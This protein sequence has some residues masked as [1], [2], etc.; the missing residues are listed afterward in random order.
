MKNFYAV[1][2][3]TLPFFLIIIS[4]SLSWAQVP[5]NYYDGISG[6]GYTLKTNLHNLI[7]GHTSRTYDQLW[8]DM[9]STD[10]D[11]VYEGDGTV[12]DMYSEN[13]TGADPYNFTW[14]TDQCGNYG[15]EG[16]CYNREHSFPKSW[17]ND[18][19]P[20]YTDLFHLYPTDGYV[21]GQRGNFPFG[22]TDSPT[23]TS[24]NGSEKGPSS[25]P[26]YTGTVFEP[27]EEF[28]GDFARTYFYMATRYEDVI[29]SWPGSDMLDGSSD[30]VFT[31]WALNML[32]DWHET[33]AVSQKEIDRN[34]AVYD[35]QGNANPFIDH[36]EWVCEIWGSSCGP[37][38]SASASNISG[39]TYVVGNGP[40]A[41]Q[42]FELSG[43]NLDGS[44]VTLTAPT[45]Y[46]ISTDNSTFSGSLNVNYTA[47]TLSATTIYIRLKSGLAEGTY[48]N[49]VVTCNDNGTASNVTVSNSGEVTGTDPTLS[50]NPSSL[51]GFS[52]IVGNGPSTAQSFTLSGTYLDGTQVSVTAP[53]NYEIS[54]DNTTFQNNLS[55]GYTA[56]DLNTTTIY[57][58]L[59]AGLSVGT[60]NSEDVICSDNGTAPNATVTNSGTVNSSS[61]C[62]NFDTGLASSYTTG[63]QT[64]SSGDWYTTDVFAEASSDARGGTG[65]AARINDD[66][67]GASLRTPALSTVGNITFWYR[68]LNSGGGTFNIEKS[69]DGSTWTNVTSQAFSGATYTEFS[70]DINDGSNPVYI[71]I[72]N[73]N[74][75]GHLIIDD[76][77]WIAY[78]G[79]TPALSAT[80][81]SLSGYSY[82]EGS[83]PSTSQSFSLSGSDL[84]GT[85]IT[86]SA[87]TNYEVSLDDS[88]FGTSQS[89]TTAHANYDGTVLSAV[90][91][92]IRL[93]AGLAVATYNSENITVSGG[94]ASNISVANNGEVT[95]APNPEPDNYP[96]SFTATTNGS[97][98]IDLSWTDATGTNL[99]DG[100]LI[101]ANTTGTF[102]DPADTTDPTEDSD[103]SDG[104]AT[105]KV[106]HGSGASYSF[107]GLNAST[108]YYF[109]IWPYSNSGSDIDFKTDGTPPEANATTDASVGPEIIAVQDFDGSTPD[110]PYTGTGNEGASFGKT[111]N[112][113]QIGGSNNLNLNAVDVSAY[114]SM[115]LYISDASTGGVEN[116]DALEIYVNLNGAGFPAMPDVKIQESD[117]NDNTYNA[118]WDYAAS[119]TA[120]TTAG[121]PI[122]VQGDGANGFSNIEITI[123]DGTTSVEL[124][125][126]A[127]NNNTDEY[128][129]LDDIKIEGVSGNS[130]DSDTEVTAGSGSEPATIAST[131]DAAG[132][133]IMVFDFTFTDAG[134]SD[135]LATIIDEIQITQGSA[136]DIP[137][138]TNAIAG[139]YLSG[140]DLASDLAGTVNSTN[141]T[142]AGNDM[143]S[144]A[145]NS[146]ETYT[147]KIYLRTNLSGITDNDNL[148]FALNYTNITTDAA[149]SS[150]GLGAPES[151]DANAAVTITATQLLFVSQ[152]STT[153]VN[154]VMS[155]DPTV[156]AC[157]I[158]GNIDIDYSQNISVTSSGSLSGT[159]V[160][161]TWSNGTATFSNLTHTATGTGLTLTASDGNL[162]DELSSTFDIT[163]APSTGCASDLLISEYYEG[164]SN[165]KYI[166]IY[167]GTSSDTDL[168]A[169][170]ISIYANGSSTASSEIPL[171]GTIAAGSA[172]IIANSS[173]NGTILAL[174][175]A[176]SGSLGFNG[177]DAVALRTSGGVLV[178]VIGQIGSD[179]GTEW[180]SGATSTADNTLI[181]KAEV[182]QGDTDGSNVFDPAT[183]WDGYANT[184]IYAGDHTMICGPQITVNPTSLAFGDQC[185]N[186]TSA[187]MTYTVSGSDLTSDISITAPTGYEISETSGSGFS[188]SI[189]L[190]QSGG[191]VASTTVY[192]RFTPTSVSAYS[193]NITHESTG[194]DIKYVALSGNGAENP[195]TIDSPSSANI[196]V[197]SADLGGTVT[198]TGCADVTERGIYYNTTGGFSPPGE[199]IKV[200]ETPG[201]YNTGVFS[202]NVSGLN[203]LTT[204]Y[205]QAFAT[206]S[207]GT[208]YTS[209]T[210]FT[211]TADQTSEVYA[212]GIQIPGASIASTQTAFTDAFTFVIKDNGL[213]SGDGLNT[214]VTNV[215]IY[216]HTG[217]TA[218]WTN[219]IQAVKLNDGT[220]ITLGTIDITD[221][222]INI[223]IPEGNLSANDDGTEKTVTLSFQLN[224][225]GLVDN[226]V[227]SFMI[228][229]DNHNFSTGSNS[230]EFNST[231]TG[232]DFN[233]GNFTISVTATELQFAANEPPNVG[234]I[235]QNMPTSVNAV[236]ANGNIDINATDEVTLSKAS[237]TGNMSP[238]NDIQNLVNGTYSW[239]IQFDASDDYTVTAS[240]SGLTDVT[241]G[242]ISITNVFAYQGFNSLAKDNWSYSGAVSEVNHTA[243]PDDLIG[244]F[245]DTHSGKMTGG[246][247]TMDNIDLLNYSNVT[248]SFRFAAW[249][250]GSGDELNME[251]SYDG[252]AGWDYVFV[253]AGSREYIA[254]GYSN[255][256]YD[257]GYTRDESTEGSGVDAPYNPWTIS[258]P[259][260]ET[261]FMVRFGAGSSGHNYYLEDVQLEGTFNPLTVH[262]LN[263][264]GV[265]ENSAIVNS[266]II[267]DGDLTITERGII[268]TED[269]APA[270][271][272][273]GEAGVTKIAEGNT[274]LGYYTVNIGGLTIG[275]TYH[276]RAYVLTNSETQYGETVTFTTCDGISECVNN[277]DIIISEY[278]ES[279]GGGTNNAIELYNGTG[280]DVNLKHYTLRYDNG[281]SGWNIYEPS[282]HHELG[283]VV[284]ANGNTYVIAHS[285]ANAPELELI[286]SGYAN[287]RINLAIG[288]DEQIQLLK[289]GTPIE[290]VGWE[291][292]FGEATTFA[293][294]P[295]IISP[296]TRTDLSNSSDQSCD[297]NTN[298]EWVIY[299]DNYY[300]DLSNHRDPFTWTGTTSS[301]WF[302]SS[303]WNLSRIP[304][305]SAS[306]VIDNTASNMP[307]IADPLSEGNEA[308]AYNITIQSGA[309]LTIAPS[310]KMTIQNSVTLNSP[311]EFIIQS[312][313]AGA[314]SLIF[315]GTGFEATVE[316]YLIGSQWHY[317]FAPLS[318][319]IPST[320]GTHNIYSY[321]ETQKDYWDATTNYG[322]SGWT[323]ETESLMLPNS[324]GFIHNRYGQ[325]SATVS[326]TGGMLK[327]ADKTFTVSH[328]ESGT[329]SVNENGVTEDWTYFD[330]WNLVGNPF[331]S[332]IDWD[333]VTKTNIESGIYVFDGSNYQYYISGGTDSPYNIG[334][335][336]NGGSRY[337]PA[338][339]GFMVKAN[340]G[341]GSF[342]IP[343]AAR[344][345]NSQ[346]FWK[347]SE[348]S[349]PNLLRI[350][351][352]K[353][354]F[355]DE[356]VF[357]TLPEETGVS[358]EHDGN[359]DAYKMFSLDK[360]KAQIFTQSADGANLY[361]VNSMTEISNYR[362]V[363]IGL[364]I[365]EAGEY[366][367][368]IKDN[369]F[370][371]MHLWLE[372]THNDEMINLRTVNNWTL[373]QTAEDN[374]NRYVLHFT[375][376]SQPLSN[377]ELPNQA[378]KLNE[379]ISFDL[380]KDAFTDADFGDTLNY[381]VSLS[382]GSKLPTWLSFDSENL[383]F[384]GDALELGKYSITIKASDTFN[385]TARNNFE[386][387]IYETSG[388]NDADRN[389]VNIYPNPADDKLHVRSLSENIK[390]VKVV[391]IS[392]KLII[393]KVLDGNRY[394]LDLSKLTEG[395]YFVEIQTSSHTIRKSFIKQ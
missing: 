68:E 236:D 316:R 232:G 295:D 314:G 101:T 370:E 22:E 49:E 322:I 389:S 358:N 70:Y 32:I 27:I 34:N 379:S 319:V 20:M 392:G 264:M 362:K 299:P 309:S 213:G 176:T 155:P 256:T 271:F 121:N 198:D 1:R 283:D 238:D 171:S 194:A 161:G 19:S 278:I 129:L 103:L 327:S 81:A 188:S 65:S 75:A 116:A 231:F 364:Y 373:N 173:A 253:E 352:A 216:P 4:V 235:N 24:D 95:A 105:V 185:T 258:V 181:R 223:A 162:T 177:D 104:T 98:Q 222:Y 166:E 51:S 7:N 230:S 108:A 371:N 369:T 55:I 334:I 61:T 211:T 26:G 150:F 296:R 59:K 175:H 199:G 113:Y 310:G 249:S 214:L 286:P 12:L 84:D 205:F 146:N 282:N 184:T 304:S 315:A 153:V 229:A 293:R 284:L 273:I 262:T 66:S 220:D 96:G 54:L 114:S 67:N 16:D 302:T 57:V 132:E 128:Y 63:T 325:S 94:G 359:Y 268:F 38:L 279:S 160:S 131:I 255:A 354:G 147:L 378:F 260:T 311:D 277:T 192:V 207:N 387:E 159:S 189:T 88:N 138:W 224:S 381:T 244:N 183:E 110:W 35:I 388:V 45:N 163:D 191:T 109:K 80:P 187:E 120:V 297:P 2:K 341:G 292:N 361:A 367:I 164:S 125:I 317:M 234:V 145:D 140:T 281:S 30:K 300:D 242:T 344:L 72:V 340:A 117:P 158:N 336:L 259:D 206:N 251:V 394:S 133:E 100:Y 124:K 141:I 385:E 139:A 203:G 64:L 247:V 351:I 337:I 74:Q 47:P 107:S 363:P 165:D 89:I 39:Y 122:T 349:V 227:V 339:Q 9:Q 307:V 50:V 384:S 29:A 25:Y 91:V 312:T 143:I 201:P 6:T 285:A 377:T 33:D 233:S 11:G 276:A 306:V 393:K 197:N 31:D 254:D 289:N 320:F 390:L 56:P 37:T 228:D 8:T 346:N 294:R 374:S 372:D 17:F 395:M 245:T 178:D 168:S 83:G 348:N 71:R 102:S 200:S 148:E 46:E 99:P 112:G 142:F 330:G 137:D 111:N 92:Y 23:W 226:S 190:V 243:S 53:T 343:A 324:K 196:T 342:T 170:K 208:V 225:T 240:A 303:N 135:G 347:K 274:T 179:P 10:N 329:G 237:G 269:P 149:G 265:T 221:T 123:P 270:T 204:Y 261:Q 119:G 77:C 353:D 391:D 386:L 126:V 118:S 93:K 308:G 172:F 174:A 182:L 250:A 252:G 301:D 382:D 202:V 156:K 350:Y 287:V 219:T 134:T 69:Y 127:N 323:S 218:D 78:F 157:D 151:G 21:N 318:E 215:R 193:A 375:K 266:E 241:S 40:S 48:N 335:T 154:E 195:P 82:V 18:A 14:V 186:M 291:D 52:Y 305:Y 28:K 86:I 288:G 246:F 73:D 62:E 167:N 90:T 60:Y 280:S 169:Y 366:Q 76:F 290:H 13:P 257:F 87:P 212:P 383:S 42:S 248:F 15:G 365:S 41:S 272:E 298:G 58:R 267:N 79:S 355:T 85:N 217:N 5:A 43:S 326:L 321:D 97:S 144:I 356:S 360:S 345:H 3:F 331:T 115:T 338:G 368:G 180:G 357:R 44:Q 376:N 239:S 380:P 209:E 328:T 275:T 333:A 152:P 313:D 130:T 332:A 106:T 263:H 36:P 136:N 210:E